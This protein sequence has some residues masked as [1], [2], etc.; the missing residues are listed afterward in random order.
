V[1]TV[2]QHVCTQKYYFLIR[3]TPV[4]THHRHHLKRRGRGIHHWMPVA[5]AQIDEDQE[6]FSEDIPLQPALV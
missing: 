4:M 6:V 2:K 3:L 5:T 1:W